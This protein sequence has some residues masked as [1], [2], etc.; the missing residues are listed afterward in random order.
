MENNVATGEDKAPTLEDL[1]NGRSFCRAAFS[2]LH[3]AIGGAAKPCCEFRGDFGSVKQNSIE[4]IWHDTA[5]Q[6]L[7]AKMLRNERDDRCQ[8][9]YEAED[10]GGRSLR[11]IRNVELPIETHNATPLTIESLTSELPRALDLRFSNL[12]NLSCRSCGPDASTKWFAESEKL[13]WWK[14]EPQAL[15]E[16]FSSQPAALQSLAPTLETVETIYFAGGEPLLQEQ[17]YAVLHD[18]IDRGRTDVRLTYS[19]NLTELRSKKFDILPLWSKFKHVTVMASVDGHEALGELVREGFSWDRYVKNIATIRAECPHVRIAFAITVSVF[20][21]LALP[22]LCRCLAE[23]DPARK[24]NFFFNILQEPQYYSIQILPRRMKMEAKQRLESFADELATKLRPG[25]T[26][27]RQSV[28]PIIEFMMFADH[29]D[30]IRQF[31]AHTRTLDAMRNRDSKRTIPELAPLL[32]DTP[33]E[34]LAHIAA[35]QWGKLQ[36]SFAGAR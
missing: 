34:R 2:S 13:G 6:E 9:C 22:D 11:H 3:V 7:R 20:N 10:A 31:R 32:K 29:S 16:T 14:R 8:Q 19:S 28:Q 36:A 4:D 12:C 1:Q 26:G 18:L 17:H 30:Q 21:I 5:F 33:A 24:A 35:E 23:I 15:I 25:E 27:I